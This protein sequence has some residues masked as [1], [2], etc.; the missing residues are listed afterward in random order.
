VSDAVDFDSA[1]IEARR[2]SSSHQG[3]INED[4]GWADL[5]SGLA[6]LIA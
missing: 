6:L 5:G 3:E 1:R 4:A 2:R